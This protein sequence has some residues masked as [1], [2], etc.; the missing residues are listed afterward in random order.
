MNGA[1]GSRGRRVRATPAEGVPRT[2]IALAPNPRISTGSLPDVLPRTG[3][4]MRIGHERPLLWQ[5]SRGVRRV[6]GGALASLDRC[7][8]IRT[9]RCE[10]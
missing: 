2:R 3:V 9:L 4:A 6:Q 5:D 1:C 8:L 10:P 7:W